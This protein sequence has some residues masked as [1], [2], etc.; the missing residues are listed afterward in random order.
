MRSS[1]PALHST[2]SDQF[3][4]IKEISTPPSW[5]VE[6]ARRGESSADALYGPVGYEF[7]CLRMEP[8]ELSVRNIISEDMTRSELEAMERDAHDALF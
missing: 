1:L 6:S 3:C 7:V 4:D 2:P 8:Q 5:Q